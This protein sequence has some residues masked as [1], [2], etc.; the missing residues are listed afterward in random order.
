[1]KKVYGRLATVLLMIVI[2]MA[3]LATDPYHRTVSLTGSTITSV[4]TLMRVNGYAGDPKL[5]WLTIVNAGSATVYVGNA[6]VSAANGVPIPVGGSLS[7]PAAYYGDAIQ[8]DR[9][10]LFVASTQTVSII[11]RARD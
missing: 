5:T 3:A 6:D 2:A 8:S 1:M 4:Y 9:V 11:A 10:Y 7:E